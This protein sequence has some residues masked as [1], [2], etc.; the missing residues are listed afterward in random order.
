MHGWPFAVS[1]DRHAAA[2][3]AGI[4]SLPFIPELRHA[5]FSNALRHVEALTA[6]R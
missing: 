2:D 4:V 5:A 3:L 1:W 6:L